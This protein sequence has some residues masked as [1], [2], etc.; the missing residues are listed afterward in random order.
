MKF[1]GDIGESQAA[2]YLRLHG[3]RILKRNF[4]T[5][6]GEIDIIA[7]KKGELIFV[8]VKKRKNDSFGGGSAA[9]NTAKQQ[10]IIKTAESFLSNYEKEVPCRFDV[11]E[12]N[13]NKITHIKN[14]FM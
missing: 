12:I 3:Y 1:I 8:E 5:R 7:Q 11:I 10:R 4:R 2:L 14:A 13:A 9:V 6:Q